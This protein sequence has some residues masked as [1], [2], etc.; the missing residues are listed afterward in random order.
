MRSDDAT[1]LTAPKS[2]F[3]MDFWS[4]HN[5]GDAAMQVA[6]LDM[7][8]SRF[9][10][11]TLTVS[12]EYGFN[13][14]ADIAAE[15]DHVAQI[16]PAE[17]IHGGIRRTAYPIGSAA[18]W[19]KPARSLRK[20]AFIVES[21]I[22]LLLIKLFG[23][24]AGIFFA[25]RRR[26]VFAKLAD[27]DLVVWNGRNFRSRTAKSELYD[28]WSLV[29]NPMVAQLLKRP[30]VAIGVSCWTLKTPRGRKMAA[31]VLERSDYVSAREDIT[32]DYLKTLM[33]PAR[34]AAIVRRR[35]DLSF[36]FLKH[37]VQPVRLPKA[38]GSPLTLAMTLV[39]WGESDVREQENYL[40]A[41]TDGVLALACQR[42]LHIRIV[43]Q[44][45]YG[46]QG[47]G[48]LVTELRA[49]V[50]GKV[51][52]FEVIDRKLSLEELVQNYRAADMLIGTRMHSVIFSWSVGTPAIGIA[53]D[54][55]AKWS[56]LRDLGVGDLIFP[57]GKV[58]SANLVDAAQKIPSL[59]AAAIDANVARVC[60][61]VDA[62]I[63]DWAGGKG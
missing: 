53:Y 20:I 24:S 15:L 43:P 5:R 16:V 38:D 52:S 45:P 35:P 47:Y 6:L 10:G 4:D 34:F 30:I 56:I 28:L 50:E 3:V 29:Y 63:T 42:Q 25:P 33:A 49:A 54:S 41:L 9:P 61:E 23:R 12:T 7:L 36:G 32:Y 55:G 14:E 60:K 8:K 31:R 11:A 51:A 58:T 21:L 27:A 46:P 2:I 37:H 59:D 22:A 48:T 26:N 62:N 13:Q 1:G 19:S 18:Q 44:V 57:I 40:R 17:A 39:D